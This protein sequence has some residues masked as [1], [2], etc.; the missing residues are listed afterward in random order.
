MHAKRPPATRRKQVPIPL[1]VLCL[2][3]LLRDLPLPRRTHPPLVG[4]QLALP[5]QLKER[6]DRSKRPE[7]ARGQP[8]LLAWCLWIVAAKVQD[9]GRR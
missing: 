2:N 5:R 6:T 8:E 3:L 4:R 1:L 9:S 7:A